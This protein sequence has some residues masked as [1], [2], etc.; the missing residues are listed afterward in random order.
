MEGFKKT[1][2]FASPSLQ[3]TNPLLSASVETFVNNFR[4]LV[5]RKRLLNIQRLQTANIQRRRKEEE[6]VYS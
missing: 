1:P 2:S 3:L 4:T 6:I 5:K